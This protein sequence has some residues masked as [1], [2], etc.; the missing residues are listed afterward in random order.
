MKI[1]SFIRKKFL[2][3]ILL[4]ALLAIQ[5]IGVITLPEY[6]SKIVD[7]GIRGYGIENSVPK[8]IRESEMEKLLLFIRNDDK[9]LAEFELHKKSETYSGEDVYILKENANISE[10]NKEFARATTIMQVVYKAE[11]IASINPELSKTIN[12]NI[13][14]I[15]KTGDQLIGMISSLSENMLNT[16]NNVIDGKLVGITD[17]IFLQV[18]AMYIIDEYEILGIENTQANY[19]INAV[20]EMIIIAFIIFITHITQTYYMCDFTAQ[21]SKY[22][23]ERMFEQILNSEN[24]HYDKFSI[25]SLMNRTIY[26]TQMIEKSLSLFMRLLIYVPIIF[27][28]AYI[29]I[30]KMSLYFENLLICVFAIVMFIGIISY[31]LIIPKNKRIQKLLDK[32]NSVE[33]DSLNNLFLIR[34]NGRKKQEEKFKETNGKLVTE[35]VSLLETKNISTIVSILTVYLT[36][37][38]I[39]WQGGI[40]VELGILGIGSLM[41]ILEYLFQISF[42][43]IDIFRSTMELISGYVSYRRC[44]EVLPKKSKKSKRKIKIKKI[45][46][47]EFQNVYF[48]YEKSNKYI[49]E[50]FSLK[51]E[52]G[53]HVAIIGKNASGKSTII[54]LLLKLYEVE[55]GKILINNIN[56]NSIETKSLRKRM[57]VV[58]Q[59]SKVFSGSLDENIKFG[60][61]DLNAQEINKIK[62]I[63]NL[64]ELK[65]IEKNIFAKGKNISG[66][67]KQRIAIARALAMK[68]DVLLFDN[69]YSSVD[70]ATKKDIQTN[71]MN[72]YNE[73]IIIDIGQ[74]K[75]KYFNYT[76]VVEI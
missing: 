38:F 63:A 30:R 56:I 43:C 59:E 49:L 54:K 36:G 58:L 5:A 41:A 13:S 33:R 73:K 39:L 76:K 29:K 4:C 74:E 11:S 71:I 18:S 46:T 19:I 50:K 12:Q 61:E 57:G 32:I 16:V 67:Q 15:G 10:I 2:M 1:L 42:S 60:N 8:V 35:N 51:I 65:D 68:P 44:L 40:Q 7:I 52:N 70:E 27:I 47:I 72:E 6:I 28:G 55:K 53:E 62:E 21:A 31:L 20:V 22:M 3:V 75:N 26:D 34:G 24:S 17:D 25:T 14:I 9:A 66:G 69:A 48:K 37:V 64:E 45:E 23:R